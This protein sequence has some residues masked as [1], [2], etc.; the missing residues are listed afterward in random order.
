MHLATHTVTG[1][2]ARHIKTTA[3]RVLLN[4]VRNVTQVVS[5]NHF[6]DPGIKSPFGGIDELLSL[7]RDL[8]NSGSEC[9]VAYKTFVNATAIH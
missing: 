4:G 6:F 2:F 9:C 8:A 1:V 7:F 3:F 5:G